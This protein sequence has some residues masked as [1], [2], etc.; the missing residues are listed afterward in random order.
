M[1]RAKAE[2]IFQQTQ[3]VSV[4]KCLDINKIPYYKNYNE[5][6]II[7]EVIIEEFMKVYNAKVKSIIES[8]TSL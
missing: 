4:S 7:R 5:N 2:S 1:D 3:S 8:S 6:P